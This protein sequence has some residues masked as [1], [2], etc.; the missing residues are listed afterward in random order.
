MKIKKEFNEF[1]DAVTY[2]LNQFREELNWVDYTFYFL[3]M[4]YLCIAKYGST[5][6]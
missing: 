1:Y 4:I 5:I 6:N 3:S 2:I